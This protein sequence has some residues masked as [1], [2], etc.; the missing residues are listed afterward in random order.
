MGNWTDEAERMLPYI[1]KGAQ[2]LD[3]ADALRVKTIYPK[4]EDLVKL[5]QI[6]SE[7]GFKFLFGDDLYSCN[8]ENPKFQS[9]W[10]P[11][12][13]TASEYTRI[14]ENH[15]G[16]IED[17]K[18]AARGMEYTY[19]LYYTDPEDGLLYLC[20]RNGE[21]AGGVVVL[22]YLPHELVGQYFETVVRE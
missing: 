10:I 9:D 4:W 16:T 3:C 5:G 2:A 6:E 8:N 7:P 12:Q 11:G 22:H 13:G 21:A 19:G 17:P 15:A 18:T 20:W 14:D 1:Q